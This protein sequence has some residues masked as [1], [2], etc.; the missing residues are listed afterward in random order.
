MS[1]YPPPAFLPDTFHEINGVA[2]T[3]RHFEAFARRQQTP[4]LSIHPGPTTEVTTDRTVTVMQ[5]KRSLAKIDLDANLD[6][7]PFLLRYATPALHRGMRESARQYAL[8]LS[9]NR[10]FEHVFD[11]YQYCLSPEPKALKDRPAMLTSA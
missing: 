10:V 5:L 8:G 6:Y 2:H 9:W 3:S 7:D 4:F 11:A 1:H